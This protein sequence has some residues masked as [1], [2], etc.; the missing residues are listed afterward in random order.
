MWGPVAA[1][2]DCGAGEHRQLG[3]QHGPLGQGRQV[4]DGWKG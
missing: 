3:V 1:P 2:A 4:L